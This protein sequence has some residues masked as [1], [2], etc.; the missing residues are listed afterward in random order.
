MDK[1]PQIKINENICEQSIAK[2]VE[3]P[4]KDSCEAKAA[5]APMKEIS[6]TL[7]QKLH[8]TPSLVIDSSETTDMDQNGVQTLCK[9]G[10]QIEKQEELE[11]FLNEN[12]D[13]WGMDVFRLEELSSNHPLTTIFYSIFKVKPF[14]VAVIYPV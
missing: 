14:L 7:Q 12:I 9:Y 4:R 5:I 10:I 2:Q 6:S 1:T 13:L 11:E 3:A 8:S